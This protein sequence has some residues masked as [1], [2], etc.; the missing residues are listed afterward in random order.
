MLLVLP[1]TR[2][3]ELSSSRL[4]GA[5]LQIFAVHVGHIVIGLLGLARLR[6]FVTLDIHHLLTLGFG[7]GMDLLP[8]LYYGLLL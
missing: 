6:K 2:L 3:R 7:V 8:H 1:F 4:R 5:K